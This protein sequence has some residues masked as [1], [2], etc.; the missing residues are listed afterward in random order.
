[1]QETKRITKLLVD[2]YNGSP[3]IDVNLA[4]TLKKI[5][6]GV[7]AR[8]ISP[9]WNSIWEIVNHLISWRLNVLQRIQDEIITTPGNNYFAPVEDVS[10]DAWQETIKK[11]A[12]SQ[13]QWMKLLKK[14]KRKDLEKNYS[15]NGMSYYEH[16]QGIVQHDAY[17]LGQ[18]VLLAKG[19]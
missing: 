7:A 17:H 12:D 16:I 1:M 3:W 4:G 19:L 18:I 13:Q 2:I 5:D 8:K 15:S 6:A 9:Q 14:F 10:E 11:L